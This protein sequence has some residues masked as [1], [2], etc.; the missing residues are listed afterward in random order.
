[1]RGN[2]SIH[3]PNGLVDEGVTLFPAKSSPPSRHHP[4][5]D[6]PPASKT[7]EEDL[8]PLSLPLDFHHPGEDMTAEN[9]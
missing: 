6:G 2:Q 8:L 1:M 7:S 3:K 4:A 5:H 9:F